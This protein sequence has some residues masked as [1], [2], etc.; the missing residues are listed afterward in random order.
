[1]KF[2]YEVYSFGGT[3]ESTNFAPLTPLTEKGPGQ[4]TWEGDL[5]TPGWVYGDSN[6]QK[7][8]GSCELAYPAPH[9]GAPYKHAESQG[10]RLDPTSIHTSKQNPDN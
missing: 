7:L 6:G 1:M 5:T 2:A 4:M 9:P 8:A 3:K 10:F